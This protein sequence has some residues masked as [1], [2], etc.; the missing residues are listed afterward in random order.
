MPRFDGTRGGIVVAESEI[1]VPSAARTTSN[2]QTLDPLWGYVQALRMQLDVTAAS[3]T[4]P[5]LDVVLED[6][7]DG[8][9]WN[10]VKA[11]AQKIAAGRE[12]VNVLPADQ[13]G[14]PLRMRWTIGGGT[15][16]FT[17]SVRMMPVI[18]R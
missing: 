1:V 16:S 14:Q 13:F 18:G 4:T 3:G 2:T 8:T 6:S 5:T 17:F 10:T 9:N 7:L 12:V 15:P 11:F